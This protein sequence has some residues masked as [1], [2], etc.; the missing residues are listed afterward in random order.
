MASGPFSPH[1]ASPGE[2]KAQIEAERRRSPFLVYRGAEEEQVIQVLDSGDERVRIGREPKCELC[3][4]HDDRVSRLHA[5]LE[6]VG[7]VWTLYDYGLSRNGSFVNEQRIDGRR[8]LHD[9]DVLRLGATQ[10]LFRSPVEREARET[11]AA[12]G[13]GMP[14]LNDT[15]RRILVALCRPYRDGGPFVTPA[16]NKEIAEEV[17]LSV[18][19]VKAHLGNLFELVGVEELAQHHKRARLAEL[20]LRSGLV[21]RRELTGS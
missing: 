18:D 17:S 11:E 13:G 4:D 3:L 5:E 7:D 12:T 15:Q 21:T 16:S 14:Q 10:L 9:G 19:R 6:N 2:L 20:A 1:H 8:T